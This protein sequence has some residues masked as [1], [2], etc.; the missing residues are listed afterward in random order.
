[1]MTAAEPS[2]QRFIPQ[3]YSRS[4][5]PLK[6]ISIFCDTPL[7]DDSSDLEW[8]ENHPIG[9][10]ETAALNMA[11]SFKKLGFDVNFLTN[12]HSVSKKQCDIFIVARDLDIF[13]AGIYPGHLNYLWAHDDANALKDSSLMIPDVA[14]RMFEKC[15][16]VFLLSHYHQ[17]R[18]I[19]AFNLPLEKIF[20]TTNGIPLSRFD[21]QIES[22]SG[23]ARRA[24][25]SSTPQ[26]GLEI[27]LKSWQFIKS[28][29]PDAELHVFSSFKVYGLQERKY[30]QDLYD[31]AR[32]LPG[33]YYHG[34]VGQARLRAEAQ[35]CRV[36]A[37]PCIFPE[38]SCITAM[39][40]MAAGC[41]VAGTALGALPE[42]AWQNP[43]IPLN[44]GWIEKWM[45]E[46]VRLLKDDKYYENIAKQNIVS[47]RF[48]D[49]DSVAVRWLQ[50]FQLDFLK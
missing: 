22:L 5:K 10:S 48:Y 33:V 47:S 8:G 44:K 12:R 46:V 30:F 1:M 3:V 16:A 24:Y 25:Y 14:Q 27:L 17:Q 7:I 34:S 28:A 23:R 45:I 49:W 39:E 32:S 36:L 40:A 2:K 41:A 42:T 31:L 13:E 6:T 11:L 21:L 4:G 26:R 19:Q 9:G 18:W 37:Y 20:L 29:V 35:Q 50:R 43:L 15:D 38:T